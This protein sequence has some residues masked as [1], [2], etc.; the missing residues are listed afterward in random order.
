MT[1]YNPSEVAVLVIAVVAGI[2]VLG[3]RDWLIH[4]RFAKPAIVWFILQLMAWCCTVVEGFLYPVAFNF[5][6]HL[7]YAAAAVFALIACQDLLKYARRNQ[8]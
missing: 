5:L 8:P 1:S 3:H 7:F 6:E 4:Q 2:C